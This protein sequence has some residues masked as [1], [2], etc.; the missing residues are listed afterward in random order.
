MWNTQ[1]TARGASKG[2][3]CSIRGGGFSQSVGGGILSQQ[4]GYCVGKGGK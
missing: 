1:D 3:S 4:G 2:I